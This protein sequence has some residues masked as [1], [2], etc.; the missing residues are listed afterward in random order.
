L[1]QDADDVLQGLKNEI[2]YTFKNAQKGDE[3]VIDDWTINI[4]S[5]NAH[6]LKVEG[7]EVSFQVSMTLTRSGA[8]AY[9]LPRVKFSLRE[10][11]S[12]H[13][14][15]T[16][17]WKEHKVIKVEGLHLPP[18]ES[19]EIGST[20][21][22]RGIFPYNYQNVAPD[23]IVMPISRELDSKVRNFVSGVRGF[24][25]KL[26]GHYMRM[27]Y[28]SAITITTVGYGDILP[29][30]TAA[31]FLVSIEAILGIMVVGFFLNSLTFSKEGSNKPSN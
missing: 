23:A 3:I 14:L 9:L 27:F 15:N 18:F 17:E 12:T 25:S 8:E 29:I 22:A 5:I 13:D 19:H 24:P 7:D 4:N 26:R 28:L 2:T 21:L 10:R 6:Q 30:T 16:K 31:R 20:Q 11:F 1:N